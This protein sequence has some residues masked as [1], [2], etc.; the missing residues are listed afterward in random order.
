M[1]NLDTR[2]PWRP[3]EKAHSDQR[4][5]TSWGKLADR[6]YCHAKSTGHFQVSLG[7]RGPTFRVDGSI[8]H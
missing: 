3:P 4:D 1:N 5:N 8:S 2:L 6:H 7:A